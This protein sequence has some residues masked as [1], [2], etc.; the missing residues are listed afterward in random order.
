MG[1]K[2]DKAKEEA[3]K[4]RKALKQ[5]KAANKVMRKEMGGEAEETIDSILAS[6]K[7]RT[8]AT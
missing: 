1:K 6:F 3:K 7:V 2:V 5:E 4:A 8:L